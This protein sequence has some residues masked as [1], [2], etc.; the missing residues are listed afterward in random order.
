MHD[1]DVCRLVCLSNKEYSWFTSM[2]SHSCAPISPVVQ[3]VP[4]ERPPFDN[5]ALNFK[6]PLMRCYFTSCTT[7]TSH[8][9]DR[10]PLMTLC[11]IILSVSSEMLFYQLHHSYTVRF[12]PLDRTLLT[13]TSLTNCVS[14][15]MLF[16]QLYLYDSCKSNHL[17]GQPLYTC[18]MRCNHVMY[19]FTQ[20]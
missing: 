7:C 4:L 2:R 15:E 17:T 12:E 20:T 16:H 10:T 13:T 6:V 9:L 8:T 3:L 18:L 19:F 5:S 11:S 1:S 14:N